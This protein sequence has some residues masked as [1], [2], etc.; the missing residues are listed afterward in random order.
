MNKVVGMENAGFTI[1][2]AKSYDMLHGYCI[3][4]SENQYVTWMYCE[5]ADGQDVSFYHGNYFPIEWPLP[6]KA[7]TKAYAD[8]YRRLAESFQTMSECGY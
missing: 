6:M 7:S 8:Y 2:E 4:R 1:I 5:K 3:G